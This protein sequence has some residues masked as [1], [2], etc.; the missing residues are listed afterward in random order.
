MMMHVAMP[1]GMHM[2]V[3]MS[4]FVFVFVGMPFFVEVGSH[5]TFPLP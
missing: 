2:T 3:L 1:V 4:V 5:V